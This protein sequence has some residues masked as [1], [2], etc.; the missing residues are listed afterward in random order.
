VLKVLIGG[1]LMGALAVL[2]FHQGTIHILYNYVNGIEQAVQVLGRAEGPGWDIAR[3]MPNPV[4][5]GLHIPQFF[6]AMFWGGVWGVVIG[7]LIR[8]TPLPDLATAT[9]VGAV[10]CTAVA[11]SVV[12]PAGLLMHGAEDA[13]ALARLILVN[14]AF[15]FGTGFLLRPLVL[16]RAKPPPPARRSAA[17]PPPLRRKA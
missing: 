1:F 3:A 2:S 11:V 17:R 12:A 16:K 8:W 6:S 5:P 7:A 4:V 14:A 9:L 15:G 10:G 13:G